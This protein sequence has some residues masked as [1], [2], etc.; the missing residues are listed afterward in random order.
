MSEVNDINGSKIN[1]PV[2]LEEWVKDVA[3]E[4]GREGAKEIMEGFLET[5]YHTCKVR[6]DVS[7]LGKRFFVLVAFLAGLGILNIWNLLLR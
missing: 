4:G 5:R 2:P 1:I 3:R 6:E 7:S